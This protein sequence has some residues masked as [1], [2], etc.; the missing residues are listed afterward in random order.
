MKYCSFI[1]PEYPQY[2]V[3]GEVEAQLGIVYLFSA[4]VQSS[5]NL[6][7]KIYLFT[8]FL[9]SI[10]PFGA[11]YAWNWLAEFLNMKPQW[12]AADILSAFLEVSFEIYVLTHRHLDL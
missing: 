4:I 10:N 8:L 2:L 9:E 11:R 12:I 3:D 7:D 6:G 1:V 5:S